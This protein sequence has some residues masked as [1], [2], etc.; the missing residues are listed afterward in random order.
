MLDNILPISWLQYCIVY[1]VVNFSSKL[2]WLFGPLVTCDDCSPRR[3][4]RRTDLPG[5]GKPLPLEIIIHI[6]YT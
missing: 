3:I 2:R 1:Y 6:D 4:I 5:S